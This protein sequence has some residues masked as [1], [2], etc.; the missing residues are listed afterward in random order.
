MK[1]GD[2]FQFLCTLQQVERMRKVALHN[3]GEMN[4]EEQDAQGIRA[5]VVRKEVPGR[6]GR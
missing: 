2:K 5:S 3:G 6:N 4:I 1:P